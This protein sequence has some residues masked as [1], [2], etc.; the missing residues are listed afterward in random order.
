M[1]T[2]DDARWMTVLKAID[3]TLYTTHMPVFF[4]VAGY[5]A[6]FSIGKVAPGRYVRSRGW[7]IVYPY[8]LWSA[9]F[10]V[11]MTAARLVIHVNGNMP[12]SAILHI[13]THP[14]SIF[15]FL[16][17]LLLLQLGAAILA[18]RATLAAGVVA[19]ALVGFT[20][21]SDAAPTDLLPQMIVHAPYFVAGMWLAQH[22]RALMHPIGSPVGALTI[23]FLF[24]GWAFMLWQ[25][26]DVMP[27]SLWTIPVSVLG[28]L[29]MMTAACALLR[30]GRVGRHLAWL[31]TVSLPVYLMHIIFLPV[32]PRMLSALHINSVL[33]NLAFGTMFGLYAPVVAYSVA[34]RLGLADWLALTGKSPFRRRQVAPS[35]IT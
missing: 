15:W 32:A 30:A 11:S 23:A 13:A 19:V 3:F 34:E 20:A 5:N 22:R 29:L 24:I 28:L 2:L 27:V 26:G 33:I 9:L 18:G 35:P 7:A 31:G 12:L 10:W 6:F 4:L 25:R 8:L 1:K 21:L 17:A 16:Y 14:I